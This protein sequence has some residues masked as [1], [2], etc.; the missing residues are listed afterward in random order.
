MTCVAIYS[1]TE[2][3][4]PRT[5]LLPAKLSRTRS[6]AAALFV[7]VAGLLGLSTQLQA[8][9]A[10]VTYEN[11]DRYCREVEDDYSPGFSQ[12]GSGG[13]P[14]SM[15]S[16][17]TGSDG[18]GFGDAGGSV[19]HDFI[20]VPDSIKVPNDEDNPHSEAQCSSDVSLRAAYA[21]ADLQGQTISLEVTTDSLVEITYVST[22][23][24][25][26]FW[27]TSLSIPP[28]VQADIFLGCGM[29]E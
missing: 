19:Q 28:N 15:G 16:G 18:D 26:N 7:L 14:P 20:E 17:G 6:H 11:G 22:G 13:G 1:E 10:C 21:W 29:G 24:R 23:E 27:V 5:C 12:D 3:E 2:V 25:E 9:M 4:T 8:V